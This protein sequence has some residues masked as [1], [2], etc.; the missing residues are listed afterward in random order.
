M[1]YFIIGLIGLMFI[2]K[3][4]IVELGFKVIEIVWRATERT[5][6]RIFN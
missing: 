3:E 4:T 2:S 6:N 5:Y 1:I